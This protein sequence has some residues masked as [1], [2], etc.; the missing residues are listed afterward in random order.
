VNDKSKD[1]GKTFLTLLGTH[2]ETL[3][4]ITRPRVFEFIDK[5]PTSNATKMKNFSFARQ[6]WEFLE[7]RGIVD[8]DKRNPFSE[9]KLSTKKSRSSKTPRTP[10]TKAEIETLHKEAVRSGD[11][12]L[13]DLI[14][15]GAYT[16]ARINEIC[17]LKCT[18][19]ENERGV[20]KL[21]IRQAKTDAGVREIPVHPKLKPVIKRLMTNSEDGYLMPSSG[22][23]KYNNRSG[24]YIKRFG[25]M[26]KEL[27]FSSGHVFHSIRMT[28]ATLF[29]HMESSREFE[30]VVADILGH[31]KAG[32]TFKVYSGRTSWK[33]RV[34]VINKLSYKLQLN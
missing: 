34:E 27:G 18:D 16:G 20:Y 30:G 14:A 12:D 9:L 15:I 3:E 11:Q 32:F 26:K 24:R 29:E 2:F 6:Y 25:R 7:N 22:N 1:L 28:V 23:N 13:A 31:E 17:S 8:P 10:F 21:C 33:Q 5:S 4:S 19:V